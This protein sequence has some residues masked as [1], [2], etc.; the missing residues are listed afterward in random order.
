MAVATDKAI[1]E[2]QVK[3]GE[4]G[5]PKPVTV[6][7]NFWPD[8]LTIEVRTGDTCWD[9]KQKIR[10]QTGMSLE[11][12]S[13]YVDDK[14]LDNST[15]ISGKVGQLVCRSTL[16]GG[17]VDELYPDGCWDFFCNY[18]ERCG[19]IFMYRCMVLPAYIDCP[20]DCAFFCIRIQCCQDKSDKNQ[21]T[22]GKPKIKKVEA[23]STTGIFY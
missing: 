15:V 12:I 7:S 5:V 18:G 13:L 23:T 4:S 21:T 3:L 11:H 16:K 19:G 1:K 20:Y 2:M 10:D 17:V 9:I 8:G 14:V 22:D 6:R